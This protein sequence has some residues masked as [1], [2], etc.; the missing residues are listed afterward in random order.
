MNKV[1]YL[2]E[3]DV[4]NYVNLRKV[5]S[6]DTI[7]D[8][9]TLVESFEETVKSIEYTKIKMVLEDSEKYYYMVVAGNKCKFDLFNFIDE[10][11]NGGINL[12]STNIR[13][14]FPK[15]L[16]RGVY[17]ST[18][19]V[20]DEYDDVA[21]S[22]LDED[23]L[24]FTDENMEYSLYHLKSGVSLKV[25]GSGVIIGRSP[26]KVDFFIKDNSNIGRVHCNLY[27]NKKGA[28]MV[29]DFD[30][31]NGTFVN[32]RKVHSSKDIELSEGAILLLADEEFK[33][34]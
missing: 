27:I 3:S 16:S 34:L 24:G 28:L 17:S 26:R 8:V 20:D 5:T 32:N 4:S 12:S 19:K 18:D 22:Y 21:T 14:L 25:G 23:E 7:S 10:R 1:A 33:V 2:N 9:A 6:L 30:S 15:R 31:L 29:H 13:Y 11:F